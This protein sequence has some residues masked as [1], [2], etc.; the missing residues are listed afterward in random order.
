MNGTWVPS[1]NPR[2][3]LGDAN[4]VEDVPQGNSSLHEQHVDVVLEFGHY[5][6]RCLDCL[7]VTPSHVLAV[8]KPWG[9]DGKR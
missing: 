8:K 7:S 4:I 1:T 5:E 6:I 3:S 2:V 9:G